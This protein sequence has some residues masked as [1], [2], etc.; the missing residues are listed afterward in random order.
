M[1]SLETLRVFF[2][3]SVELWEAVAPG[4]IAAVIAPGEERT[5]R[6]A[7]GP[8]LARGGPLTLRNPLLLPLAALGAAVGLAGFLAHAP[9]RPR[10]GGRGRRA[11]GGGGGGGGAPAAVA[12]AWA[13]AFLYFGLMN[14]AAIFT[15]CLL[16]LPPSQSASGPATDNL[17]MAGRAAAALDVAFTGCSSLCLLLASVAGAPKP[18]RWAARAARAAPAWLWAPVCGAALAGNLLFP[19]ARAFLNEAVYAATTLAAAAVLFVNE[20]LPTPRGAPGGGAVRAAAG[21]AWGLIAAGALDAPLRAVSGGWLT[22]A[23]AAFLACDVAFLTLSRYLT[24][25]AAGRRAA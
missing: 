1:G 23:H 5:L 22:A 24:A 4:L 7:P 21:A 10:R 16:P 15:H 12:G 25:R 18:P 13:A 20:V 17:Q 11:G 8:L 14:A 2:P 9:R 19:G 3:S 6:L